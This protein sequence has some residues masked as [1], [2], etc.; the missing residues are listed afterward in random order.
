M[1][2]QHA[3]GRYFLEDDAGTLIA[4]VTYQPIDD[5]QNVVIDHTFV[6][7]SLRGQASPVN[8]WPPSST[9]HAPRGRKSSRCAPSPATN[10]TPSPN[11]PASCA[12]C[13]KINA[14]MARPLGAPFLL[15]MQDLLPP[16]PHPRG[17]PLGRRLG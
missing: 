15:Q 2:F 5:G 7:P 8:S 12:R 13:Q 14:K 4:E 3:P 1:E 9:R 11:T 17:E 10:S 16:A 6:D